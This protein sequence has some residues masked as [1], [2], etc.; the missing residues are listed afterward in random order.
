MTEEQPELVLFFSVMSAVDEIGEICLRVF[1]GD[2]STLGSCERV[3]NKKSKVP[4]HGMSADLVANLKTIRVSRSI[5]AF[6]KSRRA[7]LH[8]MIENHTKASCQVFSSVG[9]GLILPD[10]HPKC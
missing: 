10:M 1:V 7:G 5:K 4:G 9:S 3:L 6:A 2:Y 8:V